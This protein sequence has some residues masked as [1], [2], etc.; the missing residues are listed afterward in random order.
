MGFGSIVSGVVVIILVA[1]ILVFVLVRP[2]QKQHEELDSSTQSNVTFRSEGGI[3]RTHQEEAYLKEDSTT[4]CGDLPQPPRP[5][6]TRMPK[7]K[8]KEKKQKQI[9]PVNNK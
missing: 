4:D 6:S 9:E 5:D 8:S 7:P 3:S 1:V 2:S